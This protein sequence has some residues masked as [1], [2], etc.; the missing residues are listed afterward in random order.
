MTGGVLIRAS[1]PRSNLEPKGPGRKSLS[2][3]LALAAAIHALAF[4]AMGELGVSYPLI[5]PTIEI[6]QDSF[7]ELFLEVAGPAEEATAGPE[8]EI[9]NVVPEKEPQAAEAD[10]VVAG[11]EA[12]PASLPSSAEILPGEPSRVQDGSGED[13][14][15]NLEETAPALKSYNS[16]VRTAVARHWIL[17]PAARS[18]FQPGRL[19]AV[20]TI[21][22][23]GQVQV[24]MVEESSGIPALDFAAMEA[25]RGAAPY[26]PFPPELEGHETLNFR[27]HFDYRAVQ[28]RPGSI[29]DYS[30]GQE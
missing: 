11:A 28:R 23:K 18:N 30:G 29:G 16:L 19:V 9:A 7:L 13:R 24:I 4:M 26:P 3:A 6:P 10:P 25:L 1:Q 5:P 12:A 27:F 21:S 22:R 2:L 20:L 14:T 8:A 15:V 17:P